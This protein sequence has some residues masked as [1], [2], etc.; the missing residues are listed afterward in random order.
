MPFR[1]CEIDLYGARVCRLI[2]TGWMKAYLFDSFRLVSSDSPKVTLQV[3]H[4]GE[5]A[6]VV[7]GDG[8]EDAV[9]VGGTVDPTVHGRRHHEESVHR[10]MQLKRRLPAHWTDVGS[11]ALGIA[12][13]RADDT[14]RQPWLR[15]HCV[16][17]NDLRAVCVCTRICLSQIL[18]SD[19]A[20]KRVK[21][22]RHPDQRMS[23]REIDD[24]E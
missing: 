8:V 24:G 17:L 19:G 7:P 11:A 20:L 1:R 4:L 16:R 21:T 9:A 12:F 6:V 18:T 23:R 22:V 3:R 13:E 15:P 5:H 10:R 2:A 14:G